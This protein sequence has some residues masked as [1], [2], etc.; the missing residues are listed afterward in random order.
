M[1]GGFYIKKLKLRKSSNPKDRK[2]SA[3]CTSTVGA[4]RYTNNQSYGSDNI[5]KQQQTPRYKRGDSYKEQKEPRTFLKRN[6]SD[7]S[8]SD[9]KRNEKKVECKEFQMVVTDYS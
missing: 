4:T 5:D 9:V 3:H 6:N 8:P 2:Y 7:N 1:H